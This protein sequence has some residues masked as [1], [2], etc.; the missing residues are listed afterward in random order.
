MYKYLYDGGIHTARDFYAARLHTG[1]LFP[2]PFHSFSH[3]VVGL[4]QWDPSDGEY[5]VEILSE[6]GHQ[7]FNYY[8]EALNCFNTLVEELP[9][10]IREDIKLE[11]V[12]YH[13]GK[14]YPLQSKILMPPIFA[15]TC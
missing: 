7:T 15:D 1:I 4:W 9:G 13:L 12:Q 10:R 6:P 5:T 8:E 2:R 11:L 14:T 3:Y